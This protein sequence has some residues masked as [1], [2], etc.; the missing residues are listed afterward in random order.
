MHRRRFTVDITP[1]ALATGSLTLASPNLPGE[2][3]QDD[4]YPERTY[5][6]TQ[7]PQSEVRRE[8]DSSSDGTYD[9]GPVERNQRDTGSYAA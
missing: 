1:V 3:F 5:H 6:A 9:G 4:E 8:I 7:V 2:L